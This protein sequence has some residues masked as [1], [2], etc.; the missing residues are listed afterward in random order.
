MTCIRAGRTNL[1]I[2]RLQHQ[3]V[4]KAISVTANNFFLLIDFK[5]FI[6]LFLKIKFKGTD[7]RYTFISN[8]NFDFIQYKFFLDEIVISNKKIK[9][10]FSLGWRPELLF[11]LI[12][13]QHCPANVNSISKNIEKE[14]FFFPSPVTQ[15]R[16]KLWK[17]IVE[18]DQFFFQEPTQKYENYTFSFSYY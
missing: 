1:Y 14:I 5:L 13:G 17:R 7:R 16:V 9:N 2:W 18:S 6:S 11:R 3:T 12:Y 10:N 8:V 4:M 15:Q